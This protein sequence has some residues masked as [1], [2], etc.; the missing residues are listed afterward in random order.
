MGKIELFNK[1][2]TR[3][4]GMSVKQIKTVA[5]VEAKR[6]EQQLATNWIDAHLI[7]SE[8]KRLLTL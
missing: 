6:I 4:K 3:A 1:L 5:R 8:V 2:A 7:A